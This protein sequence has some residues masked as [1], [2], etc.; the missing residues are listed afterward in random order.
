M[1]DVDAECVVGVGVCVY[2][3]MCAQRLPKERRGVECSPPQPAPL[4]TGSGV[5]ARALE[6]REGVL[7]RA[8]HARSQRQSR[9]G[10]RIIRLSRSKSSQ[11]SA[12]V[13]FA[14]GGSAPAAAYARARARLALPTMARQR[15][16]VGSSSAAEP[17]GSTRRRHR[18]ATSSARCRREG[19]VESKWVESGGSAAKIGRQAD[20][21]HEPLQRRRR[22]QLH[23]FPSDHD[24]PFGTSCTPATYQ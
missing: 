20:A 17:A 22:L 10:R 8:L 12:G 23:F 16:I 18:R 5:V 19:A 9:R 15:A 2:V 6:H 4:Q 3:R 7:S 11:R 21:G 14:M 13:P 24:T 1:R